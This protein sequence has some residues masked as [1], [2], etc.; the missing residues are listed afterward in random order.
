M[1][2]YQARVISAPWLMEHWAGAPAGISANCKWKLLQCGRHMVCPESLNGGARAH[3]GFPYHNCPCGIQIP[4]V[5]LSASLCCFK[6]DL[7]WAMPGNKMPLVPGPG[8]ASVVPSS[9]CLAVECPSE[10]ANHTSMAAKLQELLSQIVLDI[11]NATSGDS[12]LR[13]PIFSG[14][15]CLIDHWSRRPT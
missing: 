9:P 11:S 2:P 3:A 10:V 12:I 4:L 6:W 15:S 7:L 5:G 14:P 1:Y 8:K 13:R